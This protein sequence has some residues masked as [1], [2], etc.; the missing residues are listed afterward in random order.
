VNTS[1]TES[2]SSIIGRLSLLRER[3]YVIMWSTGA[4]ASV[5]RWLELL[6]FGVYVFEVTNS[7]LQVALMTM[8]RMAPLALAGM[9][10]GAIAEMV[11]RRWLLMVGFGLML[12]QSL[13]LG[14]F[15][16]SEPVSIAWLAI[17]S[18][19]N[20]LFWTTDFSA[21]RTIMAEASG[22]ARMGVAMSLD[23]ITSNGTRMLGPALGGALLQQV[24]LAG[25]FFIGVLLYA[26]G[27]VLLLTLKHDEPDK[28]VHT[29][30][31]VFASMA[32]GLR[33]IRTNRALT[34]TLFVTI[35]FNLWGFPVTS[36]IPVIGK[37]I[38]ELNAFWVGLLVSAEGAGATLGALLITAWA[39]PQIYKSL[40]FYGVFLYLNMVLLF[41]HTLWAPLSGSFLV[42]L[43]LGGAAFAAMQ[44]VLVMLYST[45]EYR[46]RT[47]GVLAVCIGMGPIGFLHLGLLAGV[48][49]AQMATAIMAVE[50]IVA[51]LVVAVLYP[52]ID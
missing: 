29:T 46:G 30:Q 33:Y 51:L 7:P 43:G 24:G 38:L 3:T 49:G 21:R 47:M 23:S 20:G 44:A 48:V 50:G 41:S 2:A 32:Q 31:P 9:F 17:A 28:G 27:L 15:S 4:L 6:A 25:A 14:L 18:F 39:N 36:M 10:S 42:V 37:D 26:V 52:E 13:V 22:A 1:Q 11:N 5:V 16:L 35:V 12:V 19:T 40:Y 34:G 45:S 8:V